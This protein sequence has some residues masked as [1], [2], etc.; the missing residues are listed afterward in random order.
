MSD[1]RGGFDFMS[2]IKGH[3]EKNR[4]V[5]DQPEG[6]ITPVPGGGYC[7]GADREALYRDLFDNAPVGYHE[8]D[9]EGHYV[10]VNRTEAQMLGYEPSEMVGRYA[11]EFVIES[12]SRSAFAA[13]IA[14]E[15]P[16][17]AF[18]RTFRRKD[19]APIPVL[20]EERL[21][22]DGEGKPCGIR[23]TV[24]DISQ[25]K[26]AEEALKASEA[27]YRRLI[28]LSPDAILVQ[29]GDHITF[30]NDAAVR[31]LGAS[32]AGELLG[33]SVSEFVHR[34]SQSSFEI[35]PDSPQ[36]TPD[37]LRLQEHRFVTLSGERLDVE[38]ALIPF[39]AKERR[40]VQLVIR[41]ISQRR[42][43]EQ[44]IR[45]LAYQDVLTGL[46][47]RILFYDRAQIAVAQARRCE[48]SVGFLFIDLDGFK[49]VNDDWGH[50]FGDR[51]LVTV[52]HRIAREIREGDTFARFGGD[53]FVLLLPGLCDHQQA[54][55][56]AN[57]IITALRRPLVVE[58]RNVDVRASIGICIFP[59]HGEDVDLLL[60]RADAA[61]Y[62][63][64]SKGRDRAETFSFSIDPRP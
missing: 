12:I 23:T 21:I 35:V 56:V 60:M 52:A 2:Q 45:E 32:N 14:E 39:E 63:A 26:Q 30:T 38:V 61:M 31:M 17:A 3:D 18:E 59:E 43:L 36:T 46:P 16:L 40:A 4:D 53:E 64:K 8:V 19:G 49:A 33:R 29:E 44:H 22:R 55:A 57:K 47:N 42:T 7:E 20:I 28:E 48:S 5:A 11:W 6:R 25:R 41:D 10:R 1:G 50:A 51:L 58:E 15:M 13:K 54:T 24:L 9:A 34:D 37:N 27:R 62:K